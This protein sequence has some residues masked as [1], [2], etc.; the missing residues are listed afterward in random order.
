M[1]LEKKRFCD[2]SL[3]A[4]VWGFYWLKTI[5]LHT[6]SQV[7]L[8]DGQESSSKNFY[9]FSIDRYGKMAHIGGF[10]SK[11]NRSIQFQV[12]MVAFRK[13]ILMKKVWDF[14]VKERKRNDCSFSQERW[15]ERVPFFCKN[16]GTERLKLWISLIGHPKTVINNGLLSEESTL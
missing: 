3:M 14:F 5:K 8:Y 6:F 16:R 7:L 10:W 9:L 13:Q 11:R 15:T 1:H 4:Y 2:F 12:D